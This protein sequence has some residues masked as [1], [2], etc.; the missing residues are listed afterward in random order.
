MVELLDVV[1]VVFVRFLLPHIRL[2]RHLNLFPL[3]LLP[4]RLLGHVELLNR[5]VVHLHLHILLLCVLLLSD[6]VEVPI[7]QNAAPLG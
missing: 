4:L 7:L 2:D 3:H 5:F 1:E 6:L